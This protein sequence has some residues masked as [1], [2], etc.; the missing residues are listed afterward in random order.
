MDILTRRSASSVSAPFRVYRASLWFSFGKP[1]L[2]GTREAPRPK[3][4][5][6]LERNERTIA[7][8][9]PADPQAACLKARAEQGSRPEGLAAASRRLHPGLHRDPEEAELGAA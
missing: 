7:D 3:G 9:L 1:S 2:N 5:R 6:L 8:S 4:T